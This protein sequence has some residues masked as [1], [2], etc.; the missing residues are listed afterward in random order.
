MTPWDVIIDEQVKVPELEMKEHEEIEYS[1][2][3]HKDDIE[4]R[5]TI[6]KVNDA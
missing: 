6:N 3:N 2:E 5:V 1:F 4:E